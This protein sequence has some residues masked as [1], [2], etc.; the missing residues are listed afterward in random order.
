ML[1]REN[2]RN[3]DSILYLNLCFI[4]LCL[5]MPYTWYQSPVSKMKPGLDHPQHWDFVFLSCEIQFGLLQ[6][7]Y[8]PI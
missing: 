7:Q 6:E 5:D 3:Y 4:R 8:Q 1:N 2:N